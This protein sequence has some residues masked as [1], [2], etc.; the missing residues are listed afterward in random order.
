ME[1]IVYLVKPSYE[2]SAPRK[3]VLN[4]KVGIIFAFRGNIELYVCWNV[5]QYR[6]QYEFWSIAGHIG[7]ESTL[8]PTNNIDVI[9]MFK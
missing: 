4:K 2:F 6:A 9:V 8:Q 3:F 1:C 5:P 7:E